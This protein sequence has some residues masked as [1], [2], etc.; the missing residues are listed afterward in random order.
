VT[1]KH[2]RLRRALRLIPL[3]L[4]VV[5]APGPAGAQ[6]P[7][8]WPG[9]PVRFILPFPPGGGTDILGR[10]IAE[11][12]TA[13]LGQPV[14]TENRGGAGG[15][16]GAEAAAKSAPDGYTIVLVAPSL[17]ISPSLYSKLNYDPV[18]DFAPVSLVA[19]VP[20]VMVTNPAVPANTLA[21]FIRLAKSKPGEMN[22]GSGGSGTSN[23][24]AG[25]LFNIVAGVK[26]VHVPYKGVNLAMNDVLSGRIQLVVI[27]IPATVP[28]IKAGKLRALALVAPRRSPVLPDVPTVAEAGLPNFEVTTW[29]GI[30]APAGTPRPIVVRLNAELAKIMHSPELKERLDALAT[31]PVTSTPE[32]FAGLIKR[33]IA[34]WREVV[35]E[36]GLKAD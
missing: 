17:T 26:L 21:E 28:N 36:A 10:L 7:D 22:F 20:N 12:L 24:L 6:A 33:E 32:E 4:G 16:V 31:D 29:Y 1:G 30:L 15:N 18:K 27:G 35:R 2:G 19:T 14:V 25:E 8:S 34:K 11:R 5:L 3:V 9:K 13:N 23:H